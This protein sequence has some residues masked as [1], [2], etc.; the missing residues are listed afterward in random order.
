MTKLFDR[1]FGHKEET[2]ERPGDSETQALTA[3]VLLVEVAGAD[4]EFDDG[5]REK[6]ES[7]LRER[8]A[9]EP[10][11]VEEVIAAAH[12]AREGSADLFEF[13]NRINAAYG[14]DEKL[15]L[16]EAVWQVVYSDARLDAHEDYLMRKLTH[17]LRLGHADM[18]ST[19]MKVKKGILPKES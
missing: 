2:E 7:I 19:K 16:M 1:L 12:D 11:M 9:V 5:E 15:T 17:L 4:G 10:T 14:R 6:I 8:F 3:A 13:T 18:I